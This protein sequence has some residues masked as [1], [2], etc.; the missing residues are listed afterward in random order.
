MRFV[1]LSRVRAVRARKAEAPPAHATL[2]ARCEAAAEA[3]VRALCILTLTTTGA[4]LLA[5]DS[6][7]QGDGTVLMRLTLALDGPSS[8]PLEELVSQLSHDNGVRELRW[9]VDDPWKA[10]A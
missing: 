9:R 5:F 4:H 8:G 6:N 2:H 10:V 1:P 3:K 7:P